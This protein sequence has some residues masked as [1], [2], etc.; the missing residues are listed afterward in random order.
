MGLAPFLGLGPSVVGK[1]RAG[2]DRRATGPVA[3]VV[4][5]GCRTPAASAGAPGRI[6]SD[7]RAGRIPHPDT[8]TRRPALLP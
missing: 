4:A 7:P 2:G 8:S 1:V 6:R 5:D 3:V